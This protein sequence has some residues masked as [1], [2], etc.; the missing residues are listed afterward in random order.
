MIVKNVYLRVRI[1]KYKI[2]QSKNNITYNNLQNL[3]HVKT[4]FSLNKWKCDN[5]CY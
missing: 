5:V 3:I 4:K 2:V 1:E